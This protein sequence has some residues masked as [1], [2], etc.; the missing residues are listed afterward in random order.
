M[1]FLYNGLWSRSIPK[2]SVITPVFNRRKE[3]P[4]ALKSLERQTFRDIEHIVINDGSSEPLDDIM[5]EYMMRVDYPVAYITKGNGGV[6]TARNAGIKISRGE[7]MA[8]LDSDDEFRPNF[9]STFLDAWYSIPADRR[10]EYRE[11]NAF[12]ITQN[13]KRIGKHL[14][15]NI[16]ELPY[17]EAKRI[18]Y[19]AKEGE[20]TALLR[21]DLMREFPW[22][23]PDGVKCVTE[24]IIWCTLGHKYKTWFLDDELRIYHTESEDSLSHEKKS[25]Q[26]LINIIY[27][28]LW[29]INNGRKYGMSNYDI[30]RNAVIYSVFRHQLRL[31]YDYPNYDWLDRGVITRNGKIIVSVLWIPSLVVA[32]LYD[33]LKIVKVRMFK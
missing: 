17:N 20:K 25:K 16:N 32:L 3:L 27:N 31:W 2:V 12:C 13:G 23:E 29:F 24:D 10:N 21:A 7:M 11:C 26:T 15:Q 18:A 6:H 1:K 19:A 4:R 5:E 33:S 8:F 28:S 22:P 30:M 9:I 14:P